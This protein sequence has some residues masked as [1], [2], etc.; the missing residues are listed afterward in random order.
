MGAAEGR[1]PWLRKQAR[2]SGAHRDMHK[3][4]TSSKPLAGE[5]R[6]ADF[7]EFSQ[8]VGLKNWSFR[9]PQAWL[10]LS[11]DGTPLLQER[12]HASNPGVHG[13]I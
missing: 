4:N 13:T 1:G 3:G 10:R 12:R 11:P 7:H 2:Q 8:L 6:G 5:T 9:G